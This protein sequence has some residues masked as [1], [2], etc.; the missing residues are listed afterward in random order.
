MACQDVFT[1][2]E[3]WSIGLEC[4]SEDADKPL[5]VWGSGL[6]HRDHIKLEGALGAE[7]WVQIEGRHV[8]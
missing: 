7:N 6:G 4:T 3:N 2:S 5:I 8:E 1:I